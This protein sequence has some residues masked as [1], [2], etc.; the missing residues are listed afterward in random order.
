MIVRMLPLDPR[1]A[2]IVRNSCVV[3]ALVEIP[4]NRAS[5][6]EIGVT[7]YV[8]YQLERNKQSIA[9]SRFCAEG[10]SRRMLAA[11]FDHRFAVIA[12]LAIAAQ[13]R[14]VCIA[15]KVDIAAV[16]KLPA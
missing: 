2:A 13:K 8:F 5:G 12:I 15:L 6:G 1:I 11:H 9:P 16:R 7:V 3:A 4:A 10:N 14:A